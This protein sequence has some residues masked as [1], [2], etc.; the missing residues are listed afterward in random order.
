M[1]NLETFRPKLASALF[2]TLS[3][4]RMQQPT[5]TMT[6]SFG[7]LAQRTTTNWLRSPQFQRSIITAIVMLCLSS[8][9]PSAFA[10]K[11]VEP[12][13]FPPNP[14]ELK[15]PDPLLP[16]T[17]RPLTTQEQQTLRTALDELNTQATSQF[18][19]GQPEAAFEIW[20]RE[21]RLRRALGPLE[22]VA[23]LSRVGTTAWE[24]NRT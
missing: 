18:Q 1:L 3:L 6:F 14:L 15:T 13:E 24:E 23:A 19:A 22:E 12:D 16:Q 9:A 21:L 11:T 10:K 4:I 17:G 20:Y 8:Y 5:S 7:S 2:K